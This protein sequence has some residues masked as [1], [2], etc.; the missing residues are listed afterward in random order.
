MTVCSQ[1]FFLD[2]QVLSSKI[3]QS[4]K[5]VKYTIFVID[6]SVFSHLN[7]QQGQQFAANE[8]KWEHFSSNQL[9]PLAQKLI[10]HLKLGVFRVGGIT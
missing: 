2:L 3:I 7:C 8:S 1:H 4:S 10:V 6:V 9:C 5:F